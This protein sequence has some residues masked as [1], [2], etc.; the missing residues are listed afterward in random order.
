MNQTDVAVITGGGGGIGAAC[1]RR[2]AASGWRVA[3]CDIDGD[4][5]DAVAR[6]VGGV[7]L[8]L[9]IADREAVEAAAARV[10]A[11]LGSVSGLV[12]CAAHLENPHRPEQQ[13]A[14]EWQRI[15]DV[16]IGGSF[17][18]CRA[19]GARMAERGRGS[20]V[21][22]ASI[23]ALGSSPLVAY[24][25]AKAAMVAMTRNLAVAWGRRGV[26]VNCVAPGPTLTPAVVASHARGERNPETMIRATALGRLVQPD[27]IAAPVEF[28]L[29][30]A[31]AAITGVILPVDA[32]VMVTGLWQM[33][34]G[35]PD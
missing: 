21:T 31:A 17:N 20:I 11:E 7:G 13:D 15:L 22:I 5:A 19:F 10:E 4:R 8:Q 27:E 30:P 33:Y 18:T 1:V 23:T 34:G 16:N 12:A 6:E 28:L 24:G 29:S 35:V 2:L 26:R 3:V 32:G 25:P 9:D 14:Q